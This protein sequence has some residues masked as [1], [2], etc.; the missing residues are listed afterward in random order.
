MVYESMCSKPWRKH[1]NT[2][3][4][5][6]IVERK[7]VEKLLEGTG[8]NRICRE[9]KVGKRRVQN[10]RQRALEAGYLDGSTPIPAYPEALFPDPADGRALKESLGWKELTP[11]LEWIKERLESN[12]HAVTVYEELP[13]AVTRSCFYRFLAKQGLTKALHRQEQRVVP[14]IVHMPGDALQVDWGHLWNGTDSD[15]RKVKIWV[16]VGV[17]GYSR[18]TT[19][20]VMTVCDQQHTLSALAEMYEAIG[21]V[22]KRTT[23]DNPKVF[24]LK[25]DKYEPVIHPIYERF[26][27]HYGT[28]IECLMP[29]TPQHKGKV[30]RII[31]YIRRLLEAFPGDESDVAAI[32][33]YLDRK[34]ALANERCHGATR[35]RPVDRWRNEEQPVLKFL[36]QLPYDIEHYHQGRVRR[37]GHVR[38]LG[39]YYSVSEEFLNKDVVVIG[40]SRQ[41]AIYHEN[42]LIETHERVLDR[43]RTKSTKPH[44]RKP[45][46]QVCDNHEGLTAQA[47]KI[48]PCVAQM[49]DRILL[50]GDGFIDYRRIWGILSLV[51]TYP[52]DEID[53]ACEDALLNDSL[54]YAAVKSCLANARSAQALE[55]TSEPLPKASSSKFQRDISEYSQMLLNL[56]TTKGDNAYEH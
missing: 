47:L 29:R 3:T 56:G 35:E 10:T 15:G 27:S 51:K 46:E 33:A 22:P 31:P 37:D 39:K 49:V 24:A 28:T 48:G 25:A 54:S 52:N 4:K 12:W 13:V 30:E 21:G 23:S 9:L 41:V 5:R 19:A 38:F 32:Q 50:K 20:R 44:H 55:A 1:V 7:I 2:R 40:N 14:E 53:A 45:W 16:F 8:V 36:P 43:T 42:R 11:Y 6:R 26:A 18:V 34:L 17:L